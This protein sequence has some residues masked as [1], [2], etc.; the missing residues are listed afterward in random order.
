MCTAGREA[1]IPISSII[2]HKLA[3]QNTAALFENLEEKNDLHSVSLK[4]DMKI[5]QA[6]P[7]LRK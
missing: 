7:S 1:N 4:N 2:N 3:Y 6:N 5:E